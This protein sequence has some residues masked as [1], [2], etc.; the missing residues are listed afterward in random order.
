MPALG[1]ADRSAAATD[2]TLEAPPGSTGVGPFKQ[3]QQLS[4]CRDDARCA[5]EI[6]M[7][8]IGAVAGGLAIRLGDDPTSAP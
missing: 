6:R 2:A 1:D 7:L 4:P 5:M 3:L 8:Q